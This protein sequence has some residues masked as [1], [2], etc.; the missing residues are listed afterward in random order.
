MRPV[1]WH[2]PECGTSRNVL[3]VLQACDLDP[4]IVDYRQKPPDRETLMQA[5][6]D[7]GMSVHDAIRQRG[8]PYAE[9]GLDDPAL[10]DDALLDAMLRDPILINRP[11][12]RTDKGVA[13]C[14]PADR[15]FDLLDGPFPADL[16]RTD[17]APFVICGTIDATD[18]GFV[19]ALEAEGLPVSDLAGSSGRYLSY[20][21]LDG[22]VI[23]YGG[24]ELYGSDALI[25][26]VVVLPQARGLGHGKAIVPRL[27]RRAFDFGAR[28]AW[29]LTET[30]GP[31]FT[32][33]GFSDVPRE[34]APDAIRDSQEF[35]TLCP[36][37][38]TLM[39]KTIGL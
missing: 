7:A 13:L 30:A 31:A 15:V 39:R 9:L 12:V 17:A 11:F 25:R 24:F 28:N 35:S 26:S 32:K 27:L 4:L 6:A 1:I 37:S 3:H 33:L 14:R 20:A 16:T 5:I 18:R 38:A 34:R 19:A 21:T 2:N 22:T 29:L 36:A 23:G 10:D 8:T